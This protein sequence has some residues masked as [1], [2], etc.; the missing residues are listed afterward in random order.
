MEAPGY[1]G[2]ELDQ[3]QTSDQLSNKCG[4]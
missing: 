2:L 1:S 3:I 4:E